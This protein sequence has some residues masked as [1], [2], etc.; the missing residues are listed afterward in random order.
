M[1]YEKAERDI[2]QNEGVEDDEL[3]LRLAREFLIENST[4]Y[5][6]QSKN[7]AELVF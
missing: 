6:Y 7:K 2:V 5:A 4:W 1:L 3:I